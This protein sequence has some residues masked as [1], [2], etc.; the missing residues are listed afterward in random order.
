[1]VT[2]LLQP[3]LR[4]VPRRRLG[5]LR[6]SVHVYPAS[7]DLTTTL[8]C[9]PPCS[10]MPASSSPPASVCNNRTACP[11][12]P[13][14]PKHASVSELD[15]ALLRSSYSAPQSSARARLP[16][17]FLALLRLAPSPSAASMLSRRHLEISDQ[18]RWH[19]Y[20]ISS[21]QRPVS[22]P[23]PAVT[24]MGQNRLGEKGRHCFYCFSENGRICSSLA[25][26]ISL[27]W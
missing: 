17:C 3:H 14:V 18:I 15:L 13:L 16:C 19:L 10:T 22:V 9:V 24:C 20:F 12:L 2:A 23:G 21:S 26:F 1:M 25:K 11:L 4:P 8:A 5:L 7:D 27:D 6:A